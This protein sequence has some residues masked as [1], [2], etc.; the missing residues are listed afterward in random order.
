MGKTDGCMNC[1]QYV[2]LMHPNLPLVCKANGLYPRGAINTY[3]ENQVIII[4]FNVHGFQFLTY[5]ILISLWPST[6]KVVSLPLTYYPKY[7]CGE[8]IFLLFDYI[9]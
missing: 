1:A 4:H 8:V 2:E 9:T 3:M 5:Y 6:C 7:A